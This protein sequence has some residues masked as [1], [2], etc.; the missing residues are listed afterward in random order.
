MIEI[1]RKTPH[2]VLEEPKPDSVYMFC[3]TSGTTG[4]PKGAMLT[5]ESILCCMHLIDFFKLDLNEED[6]VISY[7]PYGHT[8]EQY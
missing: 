3:Y 7:L 8:F 2:V 6:C 1:G 4:D 5:H